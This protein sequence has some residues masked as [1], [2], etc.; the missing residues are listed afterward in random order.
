MNLP[1]IC[2]KEDISFE[3]S[4]VETV[5]VWCKQVFFYLKYFFRIMNNIA[6]FPNKRNCTVLFVTSVSID[7]LFYVC[8]YILTNF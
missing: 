8:S 1:Y 5:A 6:K 3:Y 7:T 2:S 4:E